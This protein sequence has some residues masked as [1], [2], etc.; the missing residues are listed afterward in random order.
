MIGSG[1]ISVATAADI[2]RA[3]TADT[4]DAAPAAIQALASLGAGGTQLQNQERDLH[5]WVPNE[6]A[7]SEQM[8]PVLLPHEI[9]HAIAMAGSRQVKTAT[10]KLVAEVISW[11]M[12][13]AL[14]GIGPAVG[15]R[16]EKLV[17]NRCSWAG[18]RLADGWHFAYFGFKADAKARKECHFFE[19]SYQCNKICEECLAE[20][21][22]KH[23]DP[24]ML[25]KN[26]F[27]GAAYWMTLLSHSDYVRSSTTPS[28]WLAMPGFHFKTAFRDPMHTIYLGTA[29]EMLEDIN[30]RLI[31]MSLWSLQEALH[32][33][34]HSGL[35]ALKEDA[36]VG[37]CENTQFT[38]R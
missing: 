34:D 27:D 1:R 37:V 12:K 38:V 28:P 29:K 30:L 26:F 8:I 31:A 10:H 15:F 3:N 16:G 4:G 19:R 5:R 7:T 36:E 23:G 6:E 11:S 20:R 2:S 22:N 21:S 35:I 18:K 14:E 17:G 32:I 9:F 33:L 24:L 13:I 25:F